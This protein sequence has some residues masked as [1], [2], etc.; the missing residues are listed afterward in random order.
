MNLVNFW[1]CA[2]SHQILTA[3][4]VRRKL[5]AGI[6][7]S[8]IG[9]ECTSRDARKSKY[10]GLFGRIVARNHGE[11][12]QELVKEL[13]CAEFLPE[14]GPLAMTR[15]S[16][17]FSRPGRP[18]DANVR[19]GDWRRRPRDGRRGPR[20]VSG[21]RPEVR[22]ARQSDLSNCIRLGVART[23]DPGM[24]QSP[25]QGLENA[26]IARLRDQGI[27]GKNPRT[28]AEINS[29]IQLDKC[30]H[31]ECAV[32]LQSRACR[33][34]GIENGKTRQACTEG[35]IRP[36]AVGRGTCPHG[37]SERPSGMGHGVFG[38][39]LCPKTSTYLRA[40]DAGTRSPPPHLR[41]RRRTGN[42][43]RWTATRIEAGLFTAGDSRMAQTTRK[44]PWRR[45][46]PASGALQQ[47]NRLLG[48]MT[49]KALTALAEPCLPADRL[50]VS[51]ALVAE[52]ARR[53]DVRATERIGGRHGPLAAAPP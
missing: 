52:T 20:L 42:G 51:G 49:R 22:R 36:F 48:L 9:S 15:N 32:R 53:A 10:S 4:K 39:L 7:Y 37:P 35:A 6:F 3:R 21:V 29:R 43:S 46:T 14:R 1:F 44:K 18:L 31:L 11:N 2:V 34:Q 23:T 8:T 50:S 30:Q 38:I 28:R 17:P 16:N 26:E 24:R 5:H 19:H 45:V 12:I 47:E 41:S 27:V 25:V 40:V 33:S 13:R